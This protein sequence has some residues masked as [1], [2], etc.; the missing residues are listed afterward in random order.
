M[1]LSKELRKE[2]R[3]YHTPECVG[4]DCEICAVLNTCDELEAKNAALEKHLEL[5]VGALERVRYPHMKMT[6]RVGPDGEVVEALVP[7]EDLSRV[8][9]VALREIGALEPKEEE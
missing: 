5:A 9:A 2:V 1:M 4:S 3:Q 6:Q 7:A 8:A